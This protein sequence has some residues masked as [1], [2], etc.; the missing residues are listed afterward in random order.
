MPPVLLQVSVCYVVLRVVCCVLFCVGLCVSVCWVVCQC[1]FFLCCL[2]QRKSSQLIFSLSKWL[3]IVFAVS[4]ATSGGQ[5]APHQRHHSR[6]K[7]K[8]I[9]NFLVFHYLPLALLIIFLFSFFYSFPL[10]FSLYLSIFIYFSF[11][12]LSVFSYT[13]HAVVEINFYRHIFSFIVLFWLEIV[14][15]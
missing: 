13:L 7:K 8:K 3:I 9:L 10:F 14:V 11:L 15:D 6:K 4:I 5:S 12:C 1:V 2:E